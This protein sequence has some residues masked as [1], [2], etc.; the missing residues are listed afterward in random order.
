[1]FE[2]QSALILLQQLREKDQGESKHVFPL[3]CVHV[4]DVILPQFSHTCS[5]DW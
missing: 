1:M 2:L 5:H 3:S 4:S